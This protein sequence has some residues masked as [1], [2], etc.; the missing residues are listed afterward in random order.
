MLNCNRG[1][2]IGRPV[3][4]LVLFVML[5]A[6]HVFSV[7]TVREEQNMTKAELHGQGIEVT[8]MRNAPAAVKEEWS[9]RPPGMA[10]EEDDKRWSHDTGD[11]TT[12][13][14]LLYPPAQHH[15]TG[16]NTINTTLLYP[17]A[18]HHG[19]GNTITNTTLLYPPAQH[20]DTGNTT[21]NTTLLYPPAQHHDTGNTTTNTTLLYPPAQHH[22]TDNSTTN[23][24]L[25]YPPAQHHDTGN[26]TTNTT[27]LYP[28]AQHH[29]TD[30]STTHTTLLYPPAQHH[31]TDNSTTNTTLLYPPAQHHSDS[32]NAPETSEPAALTDQRL[33]KLEDWSDKLSGKSSMTSGGRDTGEARGRS[34]KLSDMT[35]D[36]KDTGEERSWSGNPSDKSP[37]TSD[38]INTGEQRSWS[39]TTPQ[40]PLTTSRPELEATKQ[41]HW[42]DA[43]HG[44]TTTAWR[45]ENVRRRMER[46]KT[47]NHNERMEQLKMMSHNE[48][49]E[50][51]KTMNH[52][53]R[54]EQLKMMSHNERMEQLKAMH[55]NVSS[56]RR[57]DKAERRGVTKR[58]WEH[59]DDH[60]QR[61]MRQATYG[62]TE[63]DKFY[64]KWDC[65]CPSCPSPR[66]R[67]NLVN[68]AYKKPSSMS[69]QWESLVGP[70]GGNNGNDS[71]H[72]RFG[73]SATSNGIHTSDDDYR[74]WWWVDLN[75][76]YTISSLTLTLRND[77]WDRDYDRNFNLVITIDGEVCYEFGTVD[78]A[79]KNL[80]VRSD[81][82]CKTHIRGRHV[83]VQKRDDLLGTGKSKWYYVIFTELSIYVCLPGHYW[84]QSE[85][86]C[87]PC[88][89]PCNYI[90]DNLYGCN[91][92]VKYNVVS[93]SDAVEM[94]LL[95]YGLAAS[96][97][98]GRVVSSLSANFEECA[99][100][101]TNPGHNFFIFWIL[102]VVLV[103]HIFEFVVTPTPNFDG[104]TMTSILFLVM[105]DRVDLTSAYHP[106][107]KELCTN[108]T[109][110][111]NG[112]RQSFPCDQQPLTGSIVALQA[113]PSSSLSLCEV[114]VKGYRITE[115][116]L[117][118]SGC[119]DL[120]TTLCEEG[121]VCENRTC[122]IP[123]GGNC[124]KRGW[125]N[126]CHSLAT[127]D[128]GICK[129]KLHSNCSAPTAGDKCQR[130]TECDR[131]ANHRCK[132][133][134]GGPC[135]TV[136]DC[137]RSENYTCDALSRCRLKRGITCL[138]PEACVAGAMCRSF[139]CQCNTTIS[140]PND[141][142]CEVE[143]GYA[144]GS[145][146]GSTVCTVH[147]SCVENICQCDDGFEIFP[148]TFTCAHAVGKINSN[149]DT[150][151]STGLIC[152][153]TKC[154][155]LLKE[156]CTKTTDC[157]EETQCDET[158]NSCSVAFGEV[159]TSSDD[160][161]IAS[162]KCSTNAFNEEHVCMLEIGQ[163]CFRGNKTMCG[164][165]TVCDKDSICRLP[166][167]AQCGSNNAEYC[168]LGTRCQEGSCRRLQGAT[169]QTNGIQC[170]PGLVCD[171]LGQCRI[172]VN[173]DCSRNLRG[174]LA[175][176]SC[177]PDHKCQCQTDNCN[178]GS[179][180]IGTFCTVTPQDPQG[181][182][183]CTDR[184]V[185]CNPLSGVCDCAAKYFPVRANFTC[186]YGKGVGS[187]CNT[188][189][190]CTA[191]LVC[192]YGA[193]AI[194]AG[195]TCEGRKSFSCRRDTL[196][197]KDEFCRWT[198]AANCEKQ[199]DTCQLGLRCDSSGFC[200]VPLNKKC[201][202][203][204]ECEA[205]SSCNDT[206]R[207]CKCMEGVSEPSQQGEG[208]EPIRG[209]VGGACFLDTDNC[210]DT[211]AV[212]NN[213]KCEC[214]PGF[215]VNNEYFICNKGLGQ[216]CKKDEECLPGASCDSKNTCSLSL[217]QSCRG[218]LREHCGPLAVC[219]RND[220]CKIAVKGNCSRTGTFLCEVGTFCDWLGICS[221]Y[222]GRTCN[223]TS[224][225]PAGAMCV[226]KSCQCDEDK[227]V[228]Y[229]V[230]CKPAEGRAGADCNT[231]HT[232]CTVPGAQCD[233]GICKC[234]AGVE[235]TRDFTCAGE[236][237]T[238]ENPGSWV[239]LIVGLVVGAL[240]LFAAVLI[241]LNRR[242]RAE[243]R[244][245]EPE[246]KARRQSLADLTHLAVVVGP[247]PTVQSESSSS[248]Y[249]DAALE[250]TS[251]SLVDDL[252]EFNTSEADD[253]SVLED[254]TVDEL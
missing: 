227:A 187:S 95:D 124:A 99:G 64:E 234:N 249:P 225:C 49:M 171:S 242:R 192:D 3:S 236:S 170:L 223:S 148:L 157:R 118:D 117:G 104:D 12:N 121:R 203:H 237:E 110:R 229:D 144:S 224:L 51:L 246:L 114:E 240:L 11:T 82:N 109:G 145:C 245:F 58:S 207:Q 214:S 27:L 175:G 149:C 155:L 119:G 72:L 75:D 139:S 133:V 116:N 188:S 156:R 248:F 17:P 184:L 151:C 73:K 172:S 243:R 22:D 88:G 65:V 209:K 130:D 97:T 44:S 158:T 194:D 216:T 213:A 185:V 232:P 127:C 180:K 19:T 206:T 90:C 78:T 15:D 59:Y 67:N 230:V 5:K 14:T 233:D 24:T 54:M 57:D 123:V 50:R 1:I 89:S 43:A 201:S 129:L 166:G 167:G 40:K 143:A 113:P 154:K 21:T 153:R 226:D 25:L 100:T 26:S 107:S 34:G 45:E 199:T 205:G 186:V 4:M 238:K 53:E 84:K 68:V 250:S 60:A 252:S 62:D 31:D 96:T 132:I 251:E 219:D 93:R 218:K 241:V 39:D 228:A 141:T 212:C 126:L 61:K 105:R 137:S 247:E 136:N 56:A 174:C 168:G 111:F 210:S 13:T 20:H 77:D 135:Q 9:R 222:V 108:F 120:K 140:R 244:D 220:E 217:G 38:G 36:D 80:D 128:S 198:L 16:N 183:S 215:E 163:S 159:C 48:R 208:C 69:S 115:V 74:G 86:Q 161:C 178:P 106:P 235:T 8:P 231:V 200:K 37:I 181:K 98:D 66:K 55:L 33:K 47:M 179:G 29:D 176:A 10:V 6:L 76:L 164:D 79:L 239:G 147:A 46:L 91:I 81:F 202:Y 177:N 152:E 195:E 196:C 197:G 169:C 18:Q 35:S 7:G 103:H 87:V 190:E 221:V 204:E 160:K 253:T 2:G 182:Q 142:F 131:S 41:Q 30:N 193:C 122:R 162:T 32:S 165:G 134:P 28:P 71:V 150:V 211:N 101:G 70:C 138:D 189:S 94:S 125:K 112:T 102:D 23:T 173:E 254:S 85:S 42:Q 52:N 83:M 63:I 191:G 92:I 146:S